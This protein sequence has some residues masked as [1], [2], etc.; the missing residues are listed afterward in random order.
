MLMIFKTVKS[1]MVKTW[2]HEGKLA[3]V[4]PRLRLQRSEQ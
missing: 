3:A 2:V 4:A 1:V